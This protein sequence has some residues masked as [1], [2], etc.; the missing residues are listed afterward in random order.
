MIKRLLIIGL[1]SIGK[2]HLLIARKLLP[3]ADIRILRHKIDKNFPD[4]ADGVFFDI[5]DAIIFAPD[6][7]VL[8]NPASFHM[9][10]AEQ[11]IKI[12]CHL[13]IEKPIS[14]HNNNTHSLLESSQNCEKTIL[15]GYNLRFLSSL[16]EFKKIIDEGSFGNILSVRCEAGNYLPSWRPDTDYRKNVSAQNALGG[17]VLLELS[18]EFDYLSWLFGKIVWVSGWV[19]KVSDLDIDVEDSANLLLGLGNKGSII[20]SLNLDFIRHDPV[21]SCIVIGSNGSLRW[22]GILGIIEKWNIANNQWDILFTTENDLDESY[23]REWEHFIDCI[24]N[25]TKPLTTI[26]NGISV[27]EVVEAAKISSENDC[28]RVYLDNY[29]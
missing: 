26:D 21:R 27:L 12:G 15:V 18:H 7:V 19:G 2:R 16:N 3:E 28:T 23:Y 13:L 25:N 8:S 20:C 9:D 24:N 17:G 14:N 4:E 6:A 1:G 29:K 22:N 10:L 11:F 5:S